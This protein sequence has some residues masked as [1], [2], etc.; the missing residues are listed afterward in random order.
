MVAPG[1]RSAPGWQSRCVGG[2]GAVSNDAP[3]LVTDNAIWSTPQDALG[4]D[5][6]VGVEA[7]IRCLTCAMRIRQFGFGCDNFYELLL[8]DCA[9]G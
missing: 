1:L 5:Y 8:I 7:D 4:F 2:R 6:F 9:V 3:E